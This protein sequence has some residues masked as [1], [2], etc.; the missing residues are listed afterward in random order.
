MSFTPNIVMVVDNH[1][2]FAIRTSDV[3]EANINAY[4]L[5]NET[6]HDHGRVA[7]YRLPLQGVVVDDPV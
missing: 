3:L 6:A 2:L 5:N 7:V 1:S 4:L